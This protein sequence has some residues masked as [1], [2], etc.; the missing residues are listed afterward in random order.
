MKRVGEKF[1]V[2]Y[3]FWVGESVWLNS[4]NNEQI[5]PVL[6]AGLN[7]S[8][9]LSSSSKG[10]RQP[11]IFWFH[12]GG[13][14]VG[15]AAE[16]DW[17]PRLVNR[18]FIV[19]SIEYPLSPEHVFPDA[20]E[21]S[22]RTIKF[23]LTET[24]LSKIRQHFPNVDTYQIAVGGYSAG[25]NLAASISQRLAQEGVSLKAHLIS[26]GALRV[27]DFSQPSNSL[28]NEKFK[29]LEKYA[30]Y[31]TL[32]RGDLEFF[33]RSI[34]P[35]YETC[36]NDS[37]INVPMGLSAKSSPGIVFVGS[38]DVLRDENTQY[39]EDLKRL[40]VKSTL[41]L[42]RGTH[43]GSVLFDIDSINRAIDRLKS[44]MEMD[45]CDF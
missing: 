15:H 28:S 26:S 40:G 45:S 11:L 16:R 21:M 36:L 29:S 10:N 8:L 42:A 38:H 37:R 27:H 7:E 31:A 5:A 1:A 22:L 25:G 2:R 19:A 18:G 17:V 34:C 33:W 12:K 32:T 23:Y 35:K 13:F 30:N 14:V 39:V 20:F 44:C 6:L 43:W 4:N 3:P 41:V 24:G 9:P